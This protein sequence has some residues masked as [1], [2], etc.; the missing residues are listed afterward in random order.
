MA[1]YI[2]MLRGINVGGNKRIKMDAASPIVSK[3]LGFEQVKT[4][5][6]SGNVVFKTGK[7]SPTALSKKIEERILSGFWLC[8]LR[9][10]KDRRRNG[11]DDRKQSILE[12]ARASIRK[13]FM[14]LFLSD[15]PAPEA[16]K[17]LADADC[18]A[19]SSRRC[20]RQEKFIFIFPMESPR[21]V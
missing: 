19:R 8:C 3:R 7:A 17:K 1:I 12:G 20:L 11:Q 6:Q 14:L 15:A 2:S 13:N 10:Y 18:G 16:L 21:A 4:Y 9:H 5:I